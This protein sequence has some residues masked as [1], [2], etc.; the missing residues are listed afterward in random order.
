MKYCSETSKRAF[1]WLK[2]MQQGYDLFQ[3]FSP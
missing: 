1:D 3:A 2:C